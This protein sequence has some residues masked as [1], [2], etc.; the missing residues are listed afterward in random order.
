MINVLD[1]SCK[2]NQTKNFKLSNV[3]H[4]LL[5]FMRQ[6]GKYGRVRQAT[7]DNMAHAL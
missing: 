4:E 6:C 1:E 7:D 5:P 2:E 3:F